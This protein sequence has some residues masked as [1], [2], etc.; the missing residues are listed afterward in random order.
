MTRPTIA[1]LI[2][3]NYEASLQPA[4]VDPGARDAPPGSNATAVRRA[5]SHA[6]LRWLRSRAT[7]LG[8]NG[9]RS[10]D[11]RQ[12]FHDNRAQGTQAQARCA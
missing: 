11:A 6:T 9:V 3:V 2:R 12:Y 5:C 1:A 7:T 4:S 8:R 10:H